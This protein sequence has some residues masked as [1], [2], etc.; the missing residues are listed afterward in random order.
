MQDT[1]GTCN[2]SI[3][4]KVGV[5]LT[6]DLN[7][8][9]ETLPAIRQGRAMPFLPVTLVDIQN[10]NWFSDATNTGDVAAETFDL[11]DSF[12]PVVPAV[13]WRDSHACIDL[14]I[15]PVFY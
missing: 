10:P 13:F 8:Q 9:R 1:C 11:P 6:V 12:S 2:L 7:F 4:K 14:V 15:F 3:S 5:V